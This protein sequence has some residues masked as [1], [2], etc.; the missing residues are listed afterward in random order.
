[1]QIC[2]QAV[3]MRVAVRPPAPVPEQTGSERGLPHTGPVLAPQ[4]RHADT[5][6][7]CLLQP[8]ARVILSTL[9]AEDDAAIHPGRQ[10]HLPAESCGQG[11]DQAGQAGR[12]EDLHR[13]RN[14]PAFDFMRARIGKIECRIGGGADMHGMAV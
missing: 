14:R 9:Q 6:R 8:C 11:S 10:S 2:D 4:R 13:F 3:E 5:G 7:E 12:A 1:V